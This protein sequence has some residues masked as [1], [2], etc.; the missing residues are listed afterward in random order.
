MTENQKHTILLVFF[1]FTTGLLI[2]M[3]I[4]AYI[5]AKVY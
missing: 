3:L 1:G 4:G 2:G 5:V